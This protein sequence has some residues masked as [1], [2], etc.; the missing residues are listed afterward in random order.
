[1]KETNFH[2]LQSYC[3]I[4][5]PTQCSLNYIYY[6]YFYGIYR[7]VTIRPSIFQYWKYIK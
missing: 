7:Y 3:S 6:K 4:E 1:M 2:L 5:K